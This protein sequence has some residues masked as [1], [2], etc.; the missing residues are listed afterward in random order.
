M[1]LRNENIVFHSAVARRYGSVE[2]HAPSCGNALQWWCEPTACIAGRLEVAAEGVSKRLRQNTHGAKVNPVI[3]RLN[4]AT[5][6]TYNLRSQINI[7][8]NDLEALVVTNCRCNL[9]SFKI[10]LGEPHGS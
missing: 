10:Q 7:Q 5:T 3:V 1:Y 4:V 2:W 9:K 6:D 8:R